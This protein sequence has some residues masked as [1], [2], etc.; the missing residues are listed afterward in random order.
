MTCIYHS[1]RWALLVETGWVTAIVRVIDG[2][3]IAFMVRP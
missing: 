2:E 3:R 1:A